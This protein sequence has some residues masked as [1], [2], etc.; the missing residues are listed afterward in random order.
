MN[1][2]SKVGMGDNTTASDDDEFM[3]NIANNLTTL[4]HTAEPTAI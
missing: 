1:T 4:V 3:N 2:K